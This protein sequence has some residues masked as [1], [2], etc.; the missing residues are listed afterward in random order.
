[1]SLPINDSGLTL[2][3][4]QLFVRVLSGGESGLDDGADLVQSE[5]Q[6]TIAHGD[7]SGATRASYRGIVIGGTRTGEAE[8]SAGYAAAVEHLSGFTGHAGKPYRQDS[9]IR[10]N[11]DQR[12]IL[13]TAFTD[14]QDELETVNAGEKAVIGP[15]LQANSQTLTRLAADGIKERMR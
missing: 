6:D 15:T 10:L 8:A 14:Y 1:M 2:G 4:D 12:G 5:M 13:L 11:D 3:I 9:G 7:Q